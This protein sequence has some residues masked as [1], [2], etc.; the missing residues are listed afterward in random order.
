MA[1][2]RSIVWG[3]GMFTLATAQ[4]GCG[5]GPTV[6]PGAPDA[7]AM[8]DAASTEAV[9]PCQSLAGNRLTRAYLEPVQE[10][11]QELQIMDTLEGEACTFKLEEDGSYTCY[12]ANTSGLLYFQDAACT[13]AIVG[14]AQGS[15]PKTFAEYTRLGNDACFLGSYYRRVGV[16]SMVEGGQ[17]AFA[18]DSSGVCV[19]T[20]T[21]SLDYYLAGPELPISYFVSA[22]RETLSATNR[23][24]SSSFSGEDGSSMCD[25]QNY[26]LDRGLAISCSPD[27][28]N[29]SEVYCMPS[30]SLAIDVF[31]DSECN[32]EDSVVAVAS[33]QQEPPKYAQSFE[34]TAC[35]PY[36]LR[37]QTVSTQ[38]LGQRY[39]QIG[40]SCTAYDGENRFFST[41]DVVEYSEFVALL[42]TVEMREDR[43]KR[44]LLVDGEGSQFFYDVWRDDHLNTDCQFAASADGS[45]RC[46]P[47][48]LEERS[49]F[50]NANCT[51][52]INL[53]FR[54]NC[55]EERTHFTLPSTLGTRVLTALP[56]GE[57]VFSLEDSGCNPV[58]GSFFSPGFELAPSTFVSGTVLEL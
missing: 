48:A 35:T 14:V 15:T 8:V 32:E 46:I 54:D 39:D 10:A 9:A 22:S 19:E 28:G 37:I 11:R 57:P 24:S 41:L 6:G 43:L 51:S 50:S 42:S 52:S 34:T 31:T 4:L 23:L 38:V 7:G 20:V 18:Q 36:A 56:H 12:P 29:N 45:L 44:R 58:S 17:S 30:G 2:T 53:A 5:N 1:C 27:L 3:L 26:L 40:E 16:S 21:P 13:S 33:C 55:Q 47:T 25:S 49:F